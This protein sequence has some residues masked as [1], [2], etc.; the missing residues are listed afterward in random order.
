M[1]CN[2]VKPAFFTL[3]ALW[4]IAQ[5]IIFYKYWDVPSAFPPDAHLAFNKLMRVCG[6]GGL[7]P[8]LAEIHDEY[9]QAPGYV[10]FLWYPFYSITKN[11]L[12]YRFVNLVMNVGILYMIFDIAQK[13]FDKKTAYLSCVAY[14]SLASIAYAPI[15]LLTEV[16][17]LFF[18]LL[19]F[20]LCMSGKWR[21]LIVGGISY[22]LAYTI[23][24]QVLAFIVPS[25]IYLAIKK[26]GVTHYFAALTAI[27]VPLAILGIIINHQV[28]KPTITSTTGGYTLEMAANDDAT[29]YPNV[30]RM[31]DPHGDIYPIVSS[32]TLTY[33]QKDSILRNRG[34]AWIKTHPMQ[35]VKLVLKRIVL[36]WKS[37]FW[38]I[39]F[40]N[41]KVGF[42]NLETSLSQEQNKIK[43]F[44]MVLK[45]VLER[46]P[47]Y[48]IL[49]FFVLSVFKNKSQILSD[50]GVV[51]LVLLF[52]T[53]GSIFFPMEDRYHYQYLWV[54]SIWAAYFFANIK[55]LR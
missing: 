14:M 36:M 54:L 16:S 22:A 41:G 30:D 27:I 26:R 1:S 38:S 33:T 2:K 15:V 37:D 43:A 7:Y 20:R 51:L 10:N 19:G 9:I 13:L 47:Y 40:V 52:G 39:Q 31:E 32:K 49:I 5:L 55:V 48:L 18:S 23:K 6:G 4:V 35:Y 44:G 24:P 17:F 46:L 29:G 11:I 21:I 50:K 45:V 34:K 8:S 53:L 3:V 12:C 42:S 25:I 28:G